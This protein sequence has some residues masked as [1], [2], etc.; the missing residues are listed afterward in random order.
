MKY[1]VPVLFSLLVL[2][3]A[4]AENQSSSTPQAQTDAPSKSSWILSLLPKPFQKNPSLEMTVITE[5]SEEG[6]K[7]PPVSPDKP[8]Y[9]VPQT[10]GYV[11]M[12]DVWAGEKSLTQAE[13]E[14]ILSKAL[15]ARGY[16]PAKPPE[17]PPTLV[18][19][20]MWGS[21]SLI[22]G[23]NM[24][25]FPDRVVNNVLERA[26]LVGGRKFAKE[27]S[28]LYQDA[29]DQ[30]AAKSMIYFDPVKAFKLH[31]PKNEFLL[32]QATDDCYYVVATAYDYAALARNRRVLLWIT[33]MTVNSQGI[34]QSQSLPTLIA[35][36]APY[37]GR[38]MAEP[39]VL[40]KRTR[41]V[42]IYFGTPT[43]VEM[44]T[45]APTRK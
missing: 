43:V 32:D 19:V 36:A 13:I 15:A 28:L 10:G 6:K 24:T 22:V 2:P 5:V 4:F 33:R 41:N 1:F 29:A 31:S 9:Y 25:E 17:Q 40:I 26:T 37:F 18:V 12:G 3:A 44:P 21:H 11:Q 7:L 20:Y 16:L 30:F 8:A 38:E 35:S 23:D 42:Q 45:A 34:S 14:R 39:E 27:L